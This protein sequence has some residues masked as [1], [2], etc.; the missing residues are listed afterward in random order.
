MAR[1]SKRNRPVWPTIIALLLLGALS[2]GA[3][4]LGGRYLLRGFAPEVTDPPEPE[5]GE[6]VPEADDPPGEQEPA[7]L[8]PEGSPDPEES[9]EE[10]EEQE[11]AVEAGDEEDEEHEEAAS[12]AVTGRAMQFFRV[13]AGAFS[14]EENAVLLAEDLREMG[15]AAVVFAADEA[16][17]VVVDLVYRE[18]DA[19]ELADA[20]N[21]D[22][23][24]ALAI[25]WELSALDVALPVGESN[26]RV[27]VELTRA[28]EDLLQA[29]GGAEIDSGRSR[30]E[31]IR[32]RADEVGG[33]LAQLDADFVPEA[34]RRF[35]IDRLESH[36]HLARNDPG[37]VACHESYIRL[38]WA[39]RAARA[40]LD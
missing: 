19:R 30:N 34:Y 12:Y 27:L 31:E 15:H 36:L 9:S 33:R 23:M 38:A 3:G 5:S 39:F 4:Y 18:D 35:I 7:A 11:P 26:G 21:E 20:L 10:A 24:E 17:R 40:S 28:L 1:R 16:Y 14:V 2:I 32:V 8:E 13:Q 37:S 22:G 6:S 25:P 29:H